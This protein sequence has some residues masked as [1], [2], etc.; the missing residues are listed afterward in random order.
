[1][2]EKRRGRGKVPGLSRAAQ[3]TSSRGGGAQR[4]G[5]G[6]DRS[7]TDAQCHCMTGRFR[8]EARCQS[9]NAGDRVRLESPPWQNA[10]ERRSV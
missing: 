4:G 5:D 9:M 3:G 6:S 7:G 10:A 1:M 8:I 2:E